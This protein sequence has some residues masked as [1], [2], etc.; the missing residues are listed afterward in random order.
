M[1][2]ESSVPPDWDKRYREGYYSGV[3]EPHRLLQEFWHLMP[4]GLVVDI[5]SGTGRD[6][7]FLAE[8]GF[9]VCAID[10]SNEALR[11][12]RKDAENRGIGVSLIRGDGAALPLCKGTLAGV[13]V[14]YF[15]LR[16]SLSEIAALPRRGG[17]LMYETFLERQNCIDRMRNPD[18]LLEDGEL[19]TYFSDYDIFF[20]E[21]TVSVVEG[22]KKA[23][24]QFVGRKR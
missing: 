6:A 22:K 19:L 4:A 14:F 21:E 10:L 1:Q 18:F 9:P 7:L 20:Y 5:A 3:L 23:R 15:L 24:A 13:M 17:I 16:G 8:K 12:I 2:R 11:I